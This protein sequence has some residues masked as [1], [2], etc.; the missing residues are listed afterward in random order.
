MEGLLLVDEVLGDFVPEVY[1]PPQFSTCLSL[2]LLGAQTDAEN[3]VGIGKCVVEG[4]G[5]P[6]SLYGFVQLVETEV[7]GRKLGKIEWL[8]WL[9]SGA[10]LN[11]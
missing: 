9:H 10:F 6:R 7:N 8:L 2:L 3:A 11:V 5:L 1:G 4:Y